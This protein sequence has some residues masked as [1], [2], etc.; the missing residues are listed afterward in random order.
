MK[1]ITV[2]HYLN[3]K[4]KPSLLP[5]EDESSTL[6]SYP[7]YIYVIARNTTFRFKS[8]IFEND[9]VDLGFGHILGLDGVIQNKNGYFSVDGFE[10]LSGNSKE[11]NASLELDLKIAKWSL[12]KSDNYD[13]KVSDLYS[14]GIGPVLEN[15]LKHN[16]A[17]FKKAMEELDGFEGVTE[18]IKLK[19]QNLSDIYNLFDKICRYSSGAET[20]FWNKLKNQTVHLKLFN[21]LINEYIKQNGYLRYF[22]W[23]N[24]GHRK[25]FESFVI[26][27]INDENLLRKCLQLLDSNCP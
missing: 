5:I 14:L 13:V 25:K 1:K 7:L 2:K 22:E 12:S 20:P 9:G 11:F 6:E 24:F 23:Q 17:L 26:G 10:F 15:I 21:D 19:D 8:K 18:C 27:K 16:V 3:T 4:L